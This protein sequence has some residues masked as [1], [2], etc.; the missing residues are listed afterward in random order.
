MNNIPAYIAF[1]TETDLITYLNPV[2]DLI[3]LTHATAG[4]VKGVLKTPWENDIEGFMIDLWKRG[5]H[6][7]GHN[8]PF[9][10]SVLAWKYPKLLKDIFAALDAGLVHDTIIREK[11]LNISRHGAIDSI[12]FNGSAI[13]MNYSLVDLEKKYLN[14]DR[15][16]LKDDDDAPRN[17]YGIYK[18]IPASQWLEP[19][20]TYATDDAI[21]TGLIFV[22]QERERLAF[23]EETGI[24]PF[25]TEAAR[26]RAAFALRLIECVGSRQDGNKINEVAAE[27]EAEYNKPELREPLLK[28]GLLLPA[29]PP[30]P[31]A[32]GALEH[33]P[34]CIGHADHPEYKKGRKVKDCGCPPKMKAGEDEKNPTKP[35]F[36]YIWSLAQ[37]NPLI[38][39]WPAEAYIAKLKQAEMYDAVISEGAFRQSVLNECEEMPEDVTLK[40]DAEWQANFCVFDPLLSIWQERRSIRK[41]ITDYLPKLYYTDEEKGIKI[42]AEIIRGS[43]N[44]LVLTG[45][46]SCKTSKF[47]PSRNEQN[48][49]PRVRPCTIPR[50]G[51]VLCST[52]YNG[53]ELGTTGQKCLNLFGYSEL[54]NKINAGIDTHAFLG[55]QIAFATDSTF[56]NMCAGQNADGIYEIFE[57]TKTFKEPCE[58]GEFNTIYKHDHPKL[59]RPVLWSDFFKHYRTLAKPTGLGYP[60]G[61]GAETFIAYAKGTFGVVINLETAKRLKE[62]WLQ[63]YPEMGLYLDYVAKDCIDPH[64]PVETYT[65]DEGKEKKRVF[66]A[67]DT[68]GGMHRARCSFCECANGQAL[69]AFAAEGALDGLY[70]VQKATWLA[71]EGDLLYGVLVVNFIHDEIL[72]EQPEGADGGITMANRAR[73]IEAIMVKS[74]RKVTPDVVA[75]CTTAAMRRWYKEAKDLWTKDEAGNEKLLVWE[76]DPPKIEVP[77]VVPTGKKWYYHPESGSLCQFH[78][79][80]LLDDAE[81]GLLTELGPVVLGTEEEGK[82][83]LQKEVP[84]TAA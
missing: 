35:L 15:S 17:N 30:Q 6:S 59:D 7:I 29:I 41:I 55:A 18:N 21:D 66:F 64:H 46:S 70:E 38:K 13:R 81:A 50:D 42:P 47:Y 24:D 62:I 3:C 73:A 77:A 72:W 69:Q 9:D 19:F 2:P 34:T 68:P 67:Y 78:P 32:N 75:G 10:L 82:R 54:A 61:L 4:D 53:M 28:A 39:A 43:F 79:S 11:L 37:K 63:T 20:I 22:A 31:Y 58:S 33:L 60:G 25:K 83:L 8:T 12:E 5:D 80:E 14:V 23:I 45:R 74:M 71:E 40:V 57:L 76:P 56:A 1:D 48:V 16:S 49:D 51:N 36:R 52:D 26:M 27:F 44:S 65:D 84:A